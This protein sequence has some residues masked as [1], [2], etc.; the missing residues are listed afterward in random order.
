MKRDRNWQ[1]YLSL[2]Q[3]RYAGRVVVIA[4]GEL[5]GAGKGKDVSRFL[6]RARKM[7]PKEIP[8]I[9]QVRDPRKVYVY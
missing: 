6:A 1:K 8:L 7:Y 4:G 2:D 5:I 9:G 3:R